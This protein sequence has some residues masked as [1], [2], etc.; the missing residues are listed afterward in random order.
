MVEYR[1]GKIDPFLI[2]HDLTG[3]LV[4]MQR[5]TITGRMRYARQPATSTGP[6]RLQQQWEIICFEN[7]RAV[8]AALEWRDVPT[9][10]VE[11]YQ[12]A[13]VVSAVQSGLSTETKDY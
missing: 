8:K 13:A 3:G 5:E 10:I 2:V 6:D 12:S 4:T 1:G 7:G 9:E 11:P